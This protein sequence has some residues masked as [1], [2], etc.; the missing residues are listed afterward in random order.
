MQG[1]D[2]RPV[3][4]PDYESVRAFLSSVGWESRVGDANRFSVMMEKAD[5]TV[6]AWEGST[7][8]GFGRALCDD[9]SNGYLSMIV[10]SPEKRRQGIGREA[11]RLAA[12]GAPVR[13]RARHHGGGDRRRAREECPAHDAAAL[14]AASRFQALSFDSR[15]MSSFSWITRSE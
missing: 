12:R 8:V 15:Q 3:S 7:V 6:V 2:F 11:H 4:P 1:V 13:V 10:V 5:R 14:E 9:V